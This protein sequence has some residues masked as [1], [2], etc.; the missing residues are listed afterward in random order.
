VW[1]FIALR[2]PMKVVLLFP[3]YSNPWT[4]YLSLPVLSSFLKTLGHS[5]SV[6][7]LNLDL[8]YDS[9]HKDAI[10]REIPD[11]K[12]RKQIEDALPRL[13]KAKTVIL[14]KREGSASSKKNAKLDLK[15]AYK[16][17]FQRHE[18]MV[19]AKSLDEL[20]ECSFERDSDTLSLFYKNKVIPWLAGEQAAVVGISVPYPNQ[21]GPS[22]KLACDIKKQFP[23]IHVVLGGPQVTKFSEDLS[24]YPGLF[25]SVDTLV[26]FDGEKPLR[27]LLEVLEKNGDLSQV[28]NLVW[29]KKDRVIQNLTESPEPMNSLPTPDFD[30][31]TPD[32]YLSNIM[33]LPLITSRGCYWGKCSFCSYREI[34][35]HSLEF[36]DVRLV[37]EDMIKLSKQYHCE[38]F[39][40][41]DDAL[42][43]SRCWVLSNEMLAAGLD[44]KWWCSARL[45]RGFTAE[46]CRLMAEAGCDRVAFGLESVN[47]RVLNLMRKGVRAEN[48]KS[49][50]EHFRKAGIKTHLNVM[51]GFPTETREETEQTKRFLKENVGLY[52]TYGVQ[53]FNL[54]AGTELDRTPEKFGITRICR[55]E[56]R[57]YGFRYGYG[58]E[59]ASGLT[60]NEAEQISNDLRKGP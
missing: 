16:R 43:P 23:K 18:N 39:R 13:L 56:K 27:A 44:L 40:I 15:W 24:A 10:E 59:T 26:N 58:F 42:S 5:V 1:Y 21:I 33:M 36:R 3:P 37:L 19:A 20:M 46:V 45:E 11:P 31:L 9:L 51:I 32:R 17:L 4:P 35:A 28:P 57:R 22:V 49:I 54:E 47:Q 48:V 7:D 38:R 2:H 55:D 50:L 53:T 30:G 34:H 52:T 29:A 41:V 6:R 14:E 60:R 8:F 12:G 25:P